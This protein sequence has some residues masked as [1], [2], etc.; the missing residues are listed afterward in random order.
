MI[1]EEKIS[2][3]KR[4]GGYRI[5]DLIAE[6]GYGRTY[7]G[8]Q[9]VLGEP[10][11]IKDCS[12]IDPEMDEVLVEEAKVIWSRGEIYVMNSDG[13]GVTRLTNDSAWDGMPSWSPDGARIA[14]VSYRDGNGEIYVMNTD[15]SN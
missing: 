15:G 2:K 3:A 14:F 13:S 9:V 10:V 7:R 11:C 4:L 8:E 1:E 6:G 12:S 5:L